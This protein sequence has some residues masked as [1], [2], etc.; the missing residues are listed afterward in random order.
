MQNMKKIILSLLAMGLFVASPMTATSNNSNGM[1][2]STPKKEAKITPKALTQKLAKELKLNKQQKAKILKLNTEYAEVIACPHGNGII[3]PMCK[4]EMEGCKGSCDKQQGECKKQC[5]NDCKKEGGS[6]C[7][8]NQEGCKGK[9]GNSCKCSC[10][11]QQGECKKQCG[12][13]CKKEGGCKKECGDKCKMNHEGCKK[14]CGNSCKN[15]QN[16]CDKSCEK[17]C[18]EQKEGC[19]KNSCEDCPRTYREKMIPNKL[20]YYSNSKAVDA[21]DKHIMD[22]RA[23]RN[24]YISRL[25]TILTKEQ[26]AKYLKL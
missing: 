25:Q 4:H 16:G 26:F 15:K 6:N 20:V 22:M 24:S 19:K 11:K 21:K 13:D 9:C 2:V 12:N 3:K 14:E 5:G 23:K 8:K 18:N 17:N 10:D 7:T 1:V